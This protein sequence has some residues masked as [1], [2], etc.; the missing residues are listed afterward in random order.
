MI[1]LIISSS[2]NVVLNASSTAAVE[3]HGTCR[4]YKRSLHSGAAHPS[5]VAMSV[6]SYARHEGTRD[7]WQFNRYIK[8]KDYCR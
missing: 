3:L 1:L 5:P 8:R 7:S 4:D 2:I 6:K